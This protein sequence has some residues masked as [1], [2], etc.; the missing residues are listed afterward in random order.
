[1]DNIDSK[2]FKNAILSRLM[3]HDDMVSLILLVDIDTYA[4]HWK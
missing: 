2:F 3:S 4:M 1:M